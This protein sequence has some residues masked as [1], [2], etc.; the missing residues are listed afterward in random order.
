MKRPAQDRPQIDPGGRS[1]WRQWLEDN[2]RS[3][4]SIW[5]VLWKKNSGGPAMTM[6]D[7]VEEALAFG[8]IDSL[9]RKLDDKR[10][11]LLLSP[12]KPGSS[13]SA[14]NKAR[15]MRM[16]DRVAMAPAGLE[17]IERAKADGSWN[18]LD[19]VDRLEVPDD[20]GLALAAYPGAA[21]AFEAFPKSARRGILEWIGA[22]KTA[23]TRAKRIKTTAT[24]ASQGRRANQWK[25]PQIMP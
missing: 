19:Q 6:D 25:G 5:L 9:P 20:L 24:E 15:I 13:W 8:W 7:V 17:A 16:T 12:R 2:H 3:S 1:G 11:L 22:A 10:S 23:E 18:A 21:E 4:G 14:V